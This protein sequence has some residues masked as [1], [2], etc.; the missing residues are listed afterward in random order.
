M[1]IDL[2]VGMPDK[3]SL[4]VWS[5]NERQFSLL[6]L[7]PTRFLEKHRQKTFLWWFGFYISPNAFFVL[8]I[9]KSLFNFVFKISTTFLWWDGQWNDIYHEFLVQSKKKTSQLTEI[10]CIHCPHTEVFLEWKMHWASEESRPTNISKRVSATCH[11]KCYSLTGVL[12]IYHR[13]WVHCAWSTSTCY[14]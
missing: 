6:T 11:E 10:L 9:P 13:K 7:N 1:T 2:F 5:S 14:P 3:E 12:F 8:L 4:V